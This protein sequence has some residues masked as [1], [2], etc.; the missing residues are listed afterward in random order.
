MKEAGRALAH[1]P[2]SNAFIGS[3]LFDMAAL[4]AEGQIVEFA[5]ESIGCWSFPMQPALAAA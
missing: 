2:T 4:T 3:G 1:C 5:A